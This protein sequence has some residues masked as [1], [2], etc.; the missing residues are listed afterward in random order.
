M[1]S[2]GDGLVFECPVNEEA[3]KA[4]IDGARTWEGLDDKA[5][6]RKGAAEGSVRSGRGY[7]L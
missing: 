7:F 3:C 4:N 6:I 2:T 5:M 1:R